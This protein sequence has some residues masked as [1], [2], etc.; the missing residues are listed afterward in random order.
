MDGD[1]IPPQN[2][3]RFSTEPSGAD[4][5][6]FGSAISPPTALALLALIPALAARRRRAGARDRY[7]Q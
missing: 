5:G 6:F 3:E 7:V 2:E 1:G 4:G